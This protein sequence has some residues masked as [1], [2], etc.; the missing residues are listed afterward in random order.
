MKKIALL[1]AASLITHI[2]FG[3]CSMTLGGQNPPF[4]ICTAQLPLQLAGTPPGGNFSPTAGVI[5][6]TFSPIT[7]GSYPVTYNTPTGGSCTQIVIVSAPGQTAQIL[8]PSNPFLCQNSSPVNLTGNLGAIPGASF[9]I[10]GT[11]S[12][13]VFDPLIWGAG[14]HQIQYNY[15]DPANGCVSSDEITLNVLPTPNMDFTGWQAQYCLTD[16]PSLLIA[17]NFAPGD[18]DFSGTGVT[19]LNTFDPALAGPGFHQITHSYTD[20]SGI[21]SNSLTVT[22]EVVDVNIIPDFVSLSSIC[23]TTN[24]DTLVYTGTPIPAAFNPVYNWTLA[25]AIITYN[26][27]DTMIVNWPTQGSKDISLNITNVP[28]LNQ[29]VDKTI[30]AAMVNISFSHLNAGGCLGINDTIVYDGASLPTGAILNWTVT[31]GN[32]VSDNG[33]TIAVQWNSAGTQ[34]ITLQISGLPCTI[35]PLTQTTDIGSVEVSTISDQI[36]TRGSEVTLQTSATSSTG[37]ISTFTWLNAASLSCSDCES[38]VAAPQQTTSYTV[39]AGDN[40]GCTG[41]DEVT[42]TVIDDRNVFV[43]NIF[44]PNGDGRNDKLVITGVGIAAIEL[45][46]YDRW[47]GKVFFSTDISEEWDG[48]VNGEMLNSGVFV[49]TLLVTYFDNQTKL[50]SGNITLVH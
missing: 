17:T 43:P 34:D 33:N 27:G 37:N 50:F 30:Q 49:Y 2:C 7:P 42:I 45:N 18:S 41:S 48:T 31:N 4:F 47:G 15:I 26:G 21:C 14:I 39:I 3:Q 32:I 28:C 19:G 46:I 10:N 44:T 23:N 1:I 5:G 11:V 24:T 9:L 35:P 8:E 36:I 12:T 6:T 16:A 38:P 13:N 29:T 22:V 25:D 40:N 20:F